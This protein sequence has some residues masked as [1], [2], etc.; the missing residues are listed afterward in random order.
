MVKEG[1]WN[2]DY[3][4]KLEELKYFTKKVR[5]LTK[6]TYR[7]YKEIINPNDLKI[8]KNDYNLDHKRSIYDCFYDGLTPEQCANINNLIIISAHENYTKNKKSSITKEELL[9]LIENNKM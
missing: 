3:E 9:F 2:Y 8:S 5:S 6:K 7:K 4:N 1:H